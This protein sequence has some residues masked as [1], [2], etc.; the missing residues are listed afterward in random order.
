MYI[1]L[2]FDDIK[3][4]NMFENNSQVGHLS[5]QILFHPQTVFVILNW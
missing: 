2:F 5:V 3:L 1:F 4:Q